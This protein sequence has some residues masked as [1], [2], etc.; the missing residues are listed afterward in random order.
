[1]TTTSET[2]PPAESTSGRASGLKL[3]L[4]AVALILLLVFARR[5]GG[6]IPQ[7]AEWVESL[8]VWGPIVFIGGYALA[9]VLAIPGSLLTM[10]GGVIFGIAKGTGIVFLGASLGATLAFLV[11][12]YLARDAIEKRT[13]GNP[14]FQAIDRAVGKEGLKIVTLLR[15]SPVFP[16]TFLNFGLGLT[17]VKLRDYVIACLGMLP[18]T[19]LYVYYGRLAGDLV[20]AAS[21]QAPERG[22]QHWVILGL[23]LLA[24]V[25]VTTFVTRIAARALREHTD[26]KL[27][28]T[29]GE[30]PHA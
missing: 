30:T 22:W 29:A 19:L 4:G 12:R 21:G 6:A 13:A 20:T 18:G 23:G 5:L 7:F 25:I 8:G 9:T 1:M 11:A 17:G 3:L 26:T 27:E 28:E 2:S 16:F 24:T 10:A 15:L 14:R